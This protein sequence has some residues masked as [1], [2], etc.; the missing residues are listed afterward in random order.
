MICPHPFFIIPIKAKST[1]YEFAK[2]IISIYGINCQVNPINTEAFPLPAK[3]PKYSILSKKKIS[4][5][6]ALNIQHW[7]DALKACL[8]NL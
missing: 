4:H 1:W 7:K 3:R 8:K 5:E 2:E 6:Y